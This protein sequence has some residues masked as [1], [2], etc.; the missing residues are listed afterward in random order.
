MELTPWFPADIKPVRK[1]VYEAGSP[2]IPPWFFRWN[3]T[4]WDGWG[5]SVDFAEIHEPDDVCLQ[6]FRWRGLARKP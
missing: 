4:K 6:E 5:E 1:G 2:F 3:G